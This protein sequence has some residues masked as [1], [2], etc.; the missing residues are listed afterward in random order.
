MILPCN[1]TMTTLSREKLH[2]DSTEIMESIRLVQLC[3]CTVFRRRLISYPKASVLNLTDTSAIHGG[4]D[5]SNEL[6]R[7]IS[8]GVV[9]PGGLLKYPAT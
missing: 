1:A 6:Q 3:C 5:H 9:G 2:V 4:H 8:G 7:K